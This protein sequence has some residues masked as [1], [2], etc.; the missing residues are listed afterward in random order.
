[1]ERERKQCK[2]EM[3]PKDSPHLVTPAHPGSWSGAGAGV[4][5]TLD[6]VG[7]KLPLE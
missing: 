2:T 5:K 6:N 3:M 4:R 7:F 1:M